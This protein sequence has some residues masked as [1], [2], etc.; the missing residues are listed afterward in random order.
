[1]NLLFD[2]TVNKDTKTIY[3]TREFAAGRDLVWDAFT[4]AEILAQ[5]VA[6]KPMR[7]EIKELD[8][9]VGGRWLYAMI[10]NDGEVPV[11]FSMAEYLEIDPKDSFTTKNTFV[12][13]NDKP[14]NSMFSITTNN[15][16]EEGTDKT[17]VHIEKVF[18]DLAVLEWMATSG[19]KEGTAMGMSNLD[20][21]FERVAAQAGA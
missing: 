17:T 18:D 20:E 21:Y 3:I 11:R 7:I 6:P 19:F 13:E 1:M 9:R 10:T 16:K 15:F 12:D 4:K 5:W 2:F 8:F 14:L